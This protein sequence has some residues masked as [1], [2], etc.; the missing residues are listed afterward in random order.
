V[1]ES[2]LAKNE[3]WNKQKKQNGNNANSVITPQK[4]EKEYEI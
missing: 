1:L 4:E 2:V 3:S